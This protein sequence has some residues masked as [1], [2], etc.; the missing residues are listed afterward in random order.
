MKLFKKK[1]ENK[2]Q[3][4][5]RFI[6]EYEKT[7]GLTFDAEFNEKSSESI[8]YLA[9]V[10]IDRTPMS[11]FSKAD[12][13][14]IVNF[15]YSHLELLNQDDLL[16]VVNQVVDYN[17]F[18]VKEVEQVIESEKEERIIERRILHA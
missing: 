18:K 8:K 14:E 5:K 15:I 1:G 12:Q 3:A 9:S 17:D 6:K 13:K 4:L 16:K 2:S 11:S 10:K 7:A